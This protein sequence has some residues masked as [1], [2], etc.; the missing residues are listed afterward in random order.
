MEIILMELKKIFRPLRLLLL[1]ALL[2]Y[3]CFAVSKSQRKAVSLTDTESYPE[4][5]T[6]YDTTKGVCSIDLL[7]QDYLLENYGNTLTSADSS[8]LNS[9]RE[10]LLAQ[11]TA[12]SAQDP[13]LLRNGMV[14]DPEREEFVTWVPS[15]P[16]DVSVSTG[17]GNLPEEDFVYTVSCTNGQTRLQGTDHPIGFLSQYKTVIDWIEAEGVYHVMSYDLIGMLEDNFLIVIVFSCGALLLTVPY[18]VLEAKSRTEGLSAS[19]K[20]GR[21]HYSR[22]LVGAVLAS[23][24]VIGL[25]VL[26]AVLAFSQWKVSRYYGCDVGDAMNICWDNTSNLLFRSTAYRRFFNTTSWNGVSFGAYYGLRLLLLFLLGLS[27]NLLAAILSL[28]IR[29]AVTAIACTLPLALLL[30]VYHLAYNAPDGGFIRT[31]GHPHE[32]V[33]GVFLLT[34]MITVFRIRQAYRK[35]I[36]I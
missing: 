31:S 18:G 6:V 16:D 19:T 12:A 35:D 9:E 14:F 26:L 28:R 3:F 32:I 10:E 36:R 11:I 2:G 8:Q 5:I 24:I 4:Q 15:E 34:A 17:K 25:G 30:L 1:V 27:V 23:G 7:F 29:N 13:I 22:K 20:T 33:S 21:A